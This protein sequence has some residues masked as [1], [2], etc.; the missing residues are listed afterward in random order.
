MLIN[1]RDEFMEQQLRIDG[2]VVMSIWYNIHTSE[3]TSFQRGVN[4]FRC[5]GL[6]WPTAGGAA[7]EESMLPDTFKKAL[8]DNF[9][10]ALRGLS[11]D[12]DVVQESKQYARILINVVEQLE[13]I[14]NNEWTTAA[15]MKVAIKTIWTYTLGAVLDTMA[16]D[17]INKKH[18]SALTSID[19]QVIK[20][21][22]KS[23]RSYGPVTQYR[24]MEKLTDKVGRDGNT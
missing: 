24:E 6:R 23:G 20:D 10:A 12:Y 18:E 9:R 21:M 14:L 5:L 1:N 7:R 13:E 17:D 8:W 16:A 3:P 22:I 4:R 15:A 2:R 19:T 11:R